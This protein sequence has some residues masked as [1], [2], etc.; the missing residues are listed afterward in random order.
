MGRFIVF[1][2]FILGLVY[3]ELS[4]GSDFRPMSEIVASAE[5]DVRVVP[6]EEVI[7]LAALSG[8]DQLQAPDGEAVIT[9]AVQTG[10]A[11]IQNASM[12]IGEADVLQGELSQVE[13]VAAPPADL[14]YVAG[15]RV[16]VREGPSTS[17]GVVTTLSR[18]AETEVIGNNGQG[19]LEIRIVGQTETG[20]MAERLLTAGG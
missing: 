14:R 19:W 10:E 11:V 8:A 15:S 13:E 6:E 7:E 16:N 12:Q 17:F 4:G 9:Q 2:F 18:G 20:W 1:T 5:A 3:Y